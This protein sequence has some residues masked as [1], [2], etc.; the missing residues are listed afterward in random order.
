MI[1]EKEGALG[2]I[3]L[4]GVLGASGEGALGAGALPEA[5]TGAELRVVG[6]AV[7]GGRAVAEGLAAAEG[8]AA[9]EGSAAVVLCF[10]AAVFLP[11]TFF[12]GAARF[13][14]M[15]VSGSGAKMS[16]FLT[17][18]LLLRVWGAILVR[19][20]YWYRRVGGM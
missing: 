19:F 3:R 13:L 5:G 15:R 9:R 4:G 10:L 14:V 20:C 6:P 1:G 16:L 7:L 18:P 8:P 17:M 12:F 2:V 11:A